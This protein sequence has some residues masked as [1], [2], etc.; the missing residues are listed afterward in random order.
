MIVT[1][2]EQL[3]S[4]ESLHPGFRR[5]FDAL[6]TAAGEDFQPGRQSLDGE[7][8]Y[9]VGLEYGTKPA[10]EAVYESHRRYIDIMLLLSGEELVGSTPAR[11][12]GVLL[13]PYSEKGDAALTKSGEGCSMVR[14]RPGD[15]AVFFPEEAHAPGLDA[16]GAQ[17]VR[18]LIVKVRAGAQKGKQ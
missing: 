6:Q 11:R 8:L 4:Y 5:A 1:T 10:E 7:D 9:L 17:T 12:T 2:L 16:D 14:M 15:V 13:R 18:K 3:R